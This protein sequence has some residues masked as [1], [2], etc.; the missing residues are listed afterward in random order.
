MSDCEVVEKGTI[1]E[2]E[3]AR[4]LV[5]AIEEITF[6]YNRVLPYSV[7]VAY[8]KLKEHYESQDRTV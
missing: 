6:Q 7:M 4:N 5:R 8:N 2:I 3:L 1:R